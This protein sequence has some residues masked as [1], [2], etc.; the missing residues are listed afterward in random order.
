ML[1]PVSNPP[2]PWRTTD[3]EW[4]EGPPPA[5]LH[6]YEERARTILSENDSPDVGF[7]FSLNPYRGCHHACAYCYA[8]RSHQYWDF[9]AG[10]DFERRIV[11]KVNAPELLEQAFRK[12]G[13]E[14]ETIVISGNTDCYQPLEANYRLTRRCLELCRKYDNPVAIITK[15]L[16]I[17]RDI[18]VLAQLAAAAGAGVFVSV[19]FIDPEV[20]RKMEPGAPSPLRRLETVK[21]LNDAGVP[22]GVSLAPLIPGLNDSTIVETLERAR[23]AG[24]RRAFTTLVRLSGE[25][26]PVFL[27]RISEQFPPERVNK[28]VNGIREMR[29]GALNDS[30]FG[31]RMEGTGPRWLLIESLFNTA[32]RKL[33]INTDDMAE[34]PRRAPPRRPVQ[35]SLF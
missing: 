16:L 8:R 35:G 18:D 9:G 17:R 1:K 15:S 31:R 11:V 20:A 23:E 7:R 30:S 32:C 29:G 21:L 27:E 10:T 19:P 28:I 4:L 13:W 26:L 2:N 25:V 3:V 34:E 14:P 33:G 22:C 6:V 24:A 12:R 5:E